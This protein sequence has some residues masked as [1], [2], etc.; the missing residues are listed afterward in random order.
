MTKV[1]ETTPKA[2]AKA[3]DA[4]SITYID[5]VTGEV[6]TIP[7]DCKVIK[8]LSDEIT[9]KAGNK[10]LAYK[11]VAKNGDL[12]QT[13]FVMSAKNVPT[14]NCSIVVKTDNMNIDK[15]S[16]R[17]PVL[18]IKTVENIVSSESLKTEQQIK[19]IEDNF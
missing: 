17:W 4:K 1:K 2:E 12:M 6:I 15:H 18:W 5:T 3:D 10:F 14:A 16:K 9:A 8:I 19:D 11:A 7:N 13:K